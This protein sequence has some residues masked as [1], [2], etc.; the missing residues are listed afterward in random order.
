MLGLD[1]ISVFLAYVGSILSALLCVIYGIVNWNKPAAGEEKEVA[2]E[3]KWEKEEI[4]IT[5]QL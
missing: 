3:A 4:K 1:G 5:E 2:E